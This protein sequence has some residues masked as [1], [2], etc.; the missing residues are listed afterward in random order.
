[1]LASM[2]V[3]HALPAGKLRSSKGEN[4]RMP[5]W[6]KWNYCENCLIRRPVD[7]IFIFTPWNKKR[8]PYMIRSL[9]HLTQC[10]HDS[11]SFLYSLGRRACSHSNSVP[12]HSSIRN[13]LKVSAELLINVT[14]PFC[15][16]EIFEHRRLN[17]T[18]NPHF[19]ITPIHTT[20]PFWPTKN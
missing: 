16:T 2:G 17:P 20:V 11:S 18:R 5:G 19:R 3:A 14:V 7:W 9:Y 12:R 6:N 8:F 13:A 4:T 15:I 1:M 10:N